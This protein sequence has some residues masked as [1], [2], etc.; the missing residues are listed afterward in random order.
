MGHLEEISGLLRNGVMTPAQRERLESIAADVAVFAGALSM[1]TGKTAQA[2]AHFEL[3]KRMARQAGNMVVLSQVLAEQA[4]LDYYGRSPETANDDPRPR[5][6][7]LGEAQALAK[8]YAPPM[9]QMAISGWLAEDKAVAKD[10]YG[11]DEAIEQSQV[12]L[13]KAML[14]GPFGAGFVSS[15]GRYSGCGEGKL[16]A[17]RGVVELTLERPSA[18]GTIERSL[19]LKMNLHSRARGLVDLAIALIG[20]KQPDEACAC[21]KRAHAIG[22]THSSATI[23]HH[24]FSARALMPREWNGLRCVWDLDDLLRAGWTT[25]AASQA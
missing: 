17:F 8:R 7:L 14:E 11:A 2:D 24:V 21:L 10:G 25:K 23:L 5:I 20:C 6:A 18:I 3:A 9:V 12:A 16:E 22:L 13:E 15:A 4:L 19:Q 1:R